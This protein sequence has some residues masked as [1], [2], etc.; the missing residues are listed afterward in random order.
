MSE[1]KIDG[2]QTKAYLPLQ[3]AWQ[4]PTNHLHFLLSVHWS[5]GLII[6]QGLAKVQSLY[7]MEN[8][9]TISML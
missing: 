5:D 2:S 8:A 4:F 7:Y 1:D 9:C 3:Q 6:Y